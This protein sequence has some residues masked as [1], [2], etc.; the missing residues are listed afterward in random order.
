MP[1]HNEAAYLE[2]AVRDVHEGLRARGLDFELLVVENGSTDDTLEIVRRLADEY[3]SVRVS[4]RPGAN[5][6]AALR[7]GLLA[8]R[9]EFVVTFD[10]DYYELGFIDRA[11]ALLE[12]RDRTPTVVVASKRA[13]GS[14]DERPWPRRFVTAVF[15]WM[16]CVGFS[17]SASETHGMKAIRRAPIETLLRQCR[18]ASDLF[19][20][21]L[22]IRAERAG[23]EV[24]ELPARTQE[25]RPSRSSIWRRVPRTLVGLVELRVTLW[26][27][28]RA[29]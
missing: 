3:P 8:S 16:L 22:V 4:S 13:A 17:L 14:R 10:V 9:G 29:E 6:G 20:T 2:T 27:E 15:G 11:L 12:A 21:E 7:E 25:L 18:F 24:A 5:Y 28:R 1:A 19:D 26:R 23:F